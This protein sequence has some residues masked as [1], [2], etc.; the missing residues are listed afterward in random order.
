VRYRGYRFP[1]AIIS[2][3]VWRSYRF[4]R[5][6]RD[7]EELMAKD[8]I[9]VSSETIRQWCR[10]FGRTCAEGVRRRHPPPQDKWHCDA[11]HLTM[12]GR[13]H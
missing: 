5:S 1:A 11:L 9:T 7:V 4:D 12:N 10:K 8:G 3:C 13:P 2:R 6:L